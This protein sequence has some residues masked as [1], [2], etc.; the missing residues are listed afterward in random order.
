MVQSG[1]DSSNISGIFKSD[2]QAKGVA[3][4]SLKE[5]FN[6]MKLDREN[7][8]NTK[9]NEKLKLQKLIKASREYIKG[10]S[11]QVMIDE[12]KVKGLEADLTRLDLEIG[13]MHEELKQLKSRKIEIPK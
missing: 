10:T 2:K 3:A 7:G 6:A 9:L 5:R 12:D 8:I 11:N 4:R 13:Q 1:F